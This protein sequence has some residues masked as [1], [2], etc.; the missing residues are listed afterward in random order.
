M[1]KIEQQ[2]IQAIKNNQDLKVANSQ[3]INY[4][5]SSDVFLHGNLIARIG[6]TWMELFDCGYQTNTTKS[7]LNALLQAFG[8]DGEYIFQRKG[9]WFLNYQGG[10]I[11]FF[12]G[13]RLNWFFTLKHWNI[14]NRQEL[15]ESYVDRLL[16]NMSTKDLLRIVGDQIEENLESYTD[17]ELI[18]EVQEYY[19]DLIEEWFDD[20]IWSQIP[21]SL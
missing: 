16:E 13:M 6:E 7:R 19:P 4:T 8:M 20:K 9:Q 18:S 3:V 12:N 15:I 1:R 2:I 17:E 21:D 5:N 11:P 10:P 14:M